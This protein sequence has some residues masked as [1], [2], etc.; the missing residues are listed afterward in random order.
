MDKKRTGYVEL[1]R[2]IMAKSMDV[3][4]DNIDMSSIFTCV[5]RS[6]EEKVEDNLEDYTLCPSNEKEIRAIIGEIGE[7]IISMIFACEYPFGDFVQNYGKWYEENLVTEF[8]KMKMRSFT[9]N[10]EN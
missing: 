1:T 3:P 5:Q 9:N 2:I 7:T 4:P 8:L 6:I 10:R